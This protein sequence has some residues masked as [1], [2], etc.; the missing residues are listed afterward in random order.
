MPLM[1]VESAKPTIL[2]VEDEVGPRNALKVI[3]RPFFN[4]YAV[5]TGQAAMRTIKERHVDL[6]TLDL[7]LP[8]RQGVNLLQ[9]IKLERDDVEVIIITGYGSLKSA[10]DGIRYG[11]AAYLLKPFNVAELIALINQTLERKRRLDRLRSVL[12]ISG[13]RWEAEQDVATIMWQLCKPEFLQPESKQDP[14]PRYREYTRHAGLLS[15][16]L[17]AKSRELFNHSSRTSFYTT[18]LAKQMQLGSGERRALAVGA[19]FHDLGEV[20]LEDRLLAQDDLRLSEQSDREMF[21]RHPEIGARMILAFEVPAEVGQIISYHHEHFDGSGYPNGLQ[22]EGIP[23][24]ARIVSIAQTFDHLVSGQTQ[25]AI[26]VD[27]ALERMRAMSRSYFDP[28]LVDL[29]LRSVAECKSSLPALAS[30][31]RSAALPDF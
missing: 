26:P 2:I 12:R 21:R 9:E 10:M 8:D 24:L 30:S 29:F 25:T 19:F 17:E 11:A 23:L 13:E 27:E 1:T 16:L 15:E 6:V 14:D 28:K 3:L 5:D 18:L 31:S 4:L 22:G 20:V 7:K